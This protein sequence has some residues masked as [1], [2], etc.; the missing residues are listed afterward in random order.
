MGIRIR[1]NVSSLIAQRHFS[2]STANVKKQMERLASGKRINRAAD[3]AAGLAIS[4]VV[5][6]DLRSLEQAR[7]NTNDGISLIQVAEGSLAEITSI[8]V[9][10]RE[11]AVQS[12]SD[13]IG[14]REREY[15]NLEYMALKDEVDR[16]TYTT[17]FNG[18]RLLTG[19]SELPM[20]LDEFNEGPPLEIQVDKDY[21]EILDHLDRDNP[22][23]IIQLDLQEINSLTEGEGSLDIGRSSNEDG[24][25]VASKD[26][27]HQSIA[28]L[29]QAMHK[30]S[31]YRARLGALQNR[32]SSA[33]R[34]L[35]MRMENLATAQS[36]IVDADFAKVSAE[37]AQQS[38]L[39]QTGASVLAQSNQLPQIAL[40]LLQ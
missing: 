1:T 28:K 5:R 10:L 3:D 25:S 20:E 18:Q 15:L 14:A 13:T 6:A 9:R 19:T 4:E 32:L 11:L 22:V 30:I 17:D 31:S 29:D 37:Y 35:G 38:I 40:K 12:A 36:R 21:Y 24:T 8:V 39:Q 27:A 16:V 7:R 2:H 33:E 34:N 26:Q 23:N